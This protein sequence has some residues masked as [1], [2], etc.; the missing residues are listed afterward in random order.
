MLQKLLLTFCLFATV[1]TGRT[2]PI[3]ENFYIKT[4]SQE[5]DRNIQRLN[6][7]D[8]G[9]PFFIS[10]RLRNTV[11]WNI[12]AERG[13]ITTPW[14]A[15]DTSR[16]A[17]VK[18]LVGNYHRNFDYLFTNASFISLPAENNADEFKRLL[19]LET[20]RIY[21]TVSQQY[22]AALAALQR[23]TVDPK[24]LALDDLSS[25][26]PIVKDYGGM[27][28]FSP[29]AAAHWQSLL[30][31]LSA[32]FIPYPR[33]TEASCRLSV[34]NG[35]EY[36]VSSEGTL[37]RKP[38]S[39]AVLTVSAALPEE[40]GNTIYEIYNDFVVDPNEL[41]A[42]D[43]LKNKVLHMISRLME[44]DSASKFEGSYLGPVLFEGRSAAGL[45]T[46]FFQ[47]S[48][49]VNRKSILYP[50][51]TT[52]FYEDK[53]GQKL[54]AATL[55]LTALPHLK[56]YGPLT[57]TGSFD[58]DYDGVTPPD[59]LVL[60]KEGV[61]KSLLNG[62][63]PT[64]KFPHSQGFAFGERSC[65]PGVLKLTADTTAPYNQMKK[66]LIKAAKEEGLPYAYIVRGTDFD[67]EQPP[68]LYRVDTATMKE[69]LVTDAKFTNFN[70]RS[71]RRFIIAADSMQLLNLESL[72]VICPQSIVIGEVELEEDNNIVKAKPVIVTNPLL[73][74]QPPPAGNKKNASRKKAF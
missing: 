1:S 73:D 13:V 11:A 68:F 34:N 32:L 14:L 3:R 42:S 61:L 52:T 50:D 47:F 20:D 16:Y 30:Q 2:Q 46:N 53:I 15:P 72:S 6:L 70:M 49:G 26:T 55:N 10:Y 67:Y 18:L 29:A 23:V 45:V 7:P 35:E 25:I 63:T 60:I 19:W 22:N 33:I 38:V 5:L 59:S 44:R 65:N 4:L 40:E 48:L 9:K 31:Q 39:R 54:I 28:E 24:E 17:A 37:I 74:K 58:V 56:K 62:R 36:L 21:K 57:A 51:N 27:R 71:L 41:P 8:L 12:R 69:Q 64:R 43:S 66:E